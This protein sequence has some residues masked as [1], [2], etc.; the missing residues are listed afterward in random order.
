MTHRL[1]EAGRASER[2]GN[3]PS[4][5]GGMRFVAGQRVSDLPEVAAPGSEIAGWS[6][7]R[8]P[9]LRKERQRKADCAKRRSGPLGLVRDQGKLMKPRR[10]KRRA[11]ARCCLRKSGRPGLLWCLK[12]EAGEGTRDDQGESESGHGDKARHNRPFYRP[13]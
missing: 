1:K 4:K 2:R 10:C 3:A 6:A 12:I 7:A 13:N 11:R 5:A 8:C 9:L